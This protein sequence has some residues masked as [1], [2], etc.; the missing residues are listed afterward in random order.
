[1]KRKVIQIANS[2]QLIS[3]PRKWSKQFGVMKGD[4]L[5]VEEKGN[6]I[7]VSTERGVSIEKTELNIDS[8]APMILRC[9]VAIYKKGV[10]EVKINFSDPTLAYEIQKSI[11]KETVG[12]E[13]V[14]QGKNYC[15]VKQVSGELGD[16]DAILRRTFL[17]L[18]NMSNDCI[19]T[20]KA[21][22]FERMNDVAFL[23]EANNRFTTTC[24]RLLN[25]KNPTSK[26]VGP[27]YYIIEE[28]ENLADQYKYLCQYIYKNKDKKII[29]KPVVIKL[30]EKTHEMLRN[31]YKLYYK[32]DKNLLV[33]IGNTRKE[34]I[35]ES[36]KLYEGKL[37]GINA[38]TLH[39]LMTI[40]QKIFCLTG[41]YLVNAI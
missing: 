11:R 25:K 14:D 22:D 29:I 27:L 18:I 6:K 39:N 1:M 2:T 37:D 4:E 26:F 41:P 7:I 24:R 20:I 36:H 40:V 32:F 8:L 3:L 34:I 12:Y 17:L 38:I 35:K 23:E 15:V 28:L 13:I 31:Y 30:F 5:E 9:L 10:D 21:R 16:F 33:E 19:N